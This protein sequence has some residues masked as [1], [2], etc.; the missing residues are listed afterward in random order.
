M[1]YFGYHS[2][3]HYLYA[4]IGQVLKSPLE[5]LENESYQ[6]VFKQKFTGAKQT[7]NKN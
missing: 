3:V 2:K 5:T 4:F 1:F 6:S 7:D